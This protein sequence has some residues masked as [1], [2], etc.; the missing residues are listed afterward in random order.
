MTMQITS[1]SM[2]QHNNT[3]SGQ[4]DAV[5]DPDDLTNSVMATLW[6]NN[7][8]S[9]ATASIRM[10][11][12]VNPVVN[13]TYHHATAPSLVPASA[14]NTHP[15]QQHTPFQSPMP[16]QLPMSPTACTITNVRG[17]SFDK[18]NYWACCHNSH[19]NMSI[20]M[21]YIWW[22]EKET[23]PWEFYCWIIQRTRVSSH[24]SQRFDHS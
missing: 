10:M 14:P 22:K 3:V 15:I 1:T 9:K 20:I 11:D 5:S 17:L 2:Q 18:W 16:Y 23:I 6:V 19:H 4:P 13:P 7:Q 24:P 8:N 12:L 21:C